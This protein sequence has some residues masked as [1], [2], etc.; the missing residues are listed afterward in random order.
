MTQ[1]VQALSLL[2]CNKERNAD[3]GVVF[4]F[5][6]ASKRCKSVVISQPCWN[7]PLTSVAMKKMKGFSPQVAFVSQSFSGVEIPTKY[8]G[9]YHLGQFELVLVYWVLQ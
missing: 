1:Y 4:N 6:S 9:M 5:W 8:V 7:I 3:S 2:A